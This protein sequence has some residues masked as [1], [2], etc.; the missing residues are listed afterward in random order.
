MTGGKSIQMLY[1][2]VLRFGQDKVDWVK[3]LDNFEPSILSMGPKYYSSHG[4]HLGRTMKL[5]GR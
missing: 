1:L 5:L 2:N 3:N 4:Q